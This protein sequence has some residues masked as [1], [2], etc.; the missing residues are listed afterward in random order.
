MDVQKRGDAISSG[1]L[2]Y[3]ELQHLYE[4]TADKLRRVAN[5]KD[6]IAMLAQQR[7]V[8][9]RNTARQRNQS[10]ARCTGS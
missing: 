5:E 1:R 6:E 9:P 8:A 2:P 3:R 7:Q 4:E 10:R